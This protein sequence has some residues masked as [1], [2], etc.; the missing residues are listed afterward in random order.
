MGRC[1]RTVIS[2]QIMELLGRRWW[3]RYPC[4]SLLRAPHQSEWLFPERTAAHGESVLGQVYHEGWWP[5]EKKKL[6]SGGRLWWRSSWRGELLQIDHNALFSPFS[7][8]QLGGGRGLGNEGTMFSLGKR[9]MEESW[10]SPCCSPSSSNWK[11]IQLIFPEL[12]YLPVRAISLSF[13]QWAFPSYFLILFIW[14]MREQLGSH[15][16]SSPD[17]LNTQE[18]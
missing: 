10:C 5:M 8:F 6:C 11:V 15:Q 13:S 18:F 9:G 2:P 7:L 12:A 16:A 3:G 1:S 14:R 17:Q 4:C